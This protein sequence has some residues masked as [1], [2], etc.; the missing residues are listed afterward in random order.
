[1][2]AGGVDA[3]EMVRTFRRGI[4]VLVVGEDTTDAAERE[5]RENG[6]NDMHRIGKLGGTRLETWSE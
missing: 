5:L 6:N 2:K 4:G 3:R 1:M